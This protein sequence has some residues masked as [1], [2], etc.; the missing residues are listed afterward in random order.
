MQQVHGGKCMKNNVLKG[1]MQQQISSAFLF[2]SKILT[3]FRMTSYGTHEKSRCV[4]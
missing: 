2:K 4:K 1:K 3:T